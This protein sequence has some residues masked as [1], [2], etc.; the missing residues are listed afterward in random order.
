MER[1]DIYLVSLDPSV[2]HEQRGRRPVLV[3]SPWEYNKIS[4][5]QIVLPITTGGT[6]VKFM[7]FTVSLENAT[8]RTTGYICCDRPRSV[9]L[10]ARDAV[11][12]EKVPKE[13]MEDVL[14]K[15]ATLLT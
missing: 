7:G 14:A 3:V 12:L 11:R 4:G 1:G 15:L 10:Q 2:G 8:T 13:I 6:F 5:T 9:D